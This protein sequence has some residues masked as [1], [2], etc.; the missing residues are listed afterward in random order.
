MQTTRGTPLT[1][2]T[3]PTSSEVPDPATP[4]RSRRCLGL[5]AA[6]AACVYALDQLAK[7]LVVARLS[8]RGPVDLVP[9]VLD[10][11]LIRNSGAAFGIGT[12][13]TLVFSL[14]A[15]AVI[16]VVLRT[17]RRLGSLAWA[18]ALGLLLGGA[19]GNLTDRLLRAPG[20]LRGHVVD[21]IELPHFPLFNVADMSI[22]TSAALIVLLSTLGRQLDG[23]RAPTGRATTT[24]E[25]DRSAGE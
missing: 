23:S 18:V 8:D 17:A 2:D 12:G 24:T 13:S 25:P 19:V 10:L 20:G 5:L 1:G 6:V 16:G 15:L 22:T 11:R 14:V 3:P 4:G 21:F 7:W 9:H